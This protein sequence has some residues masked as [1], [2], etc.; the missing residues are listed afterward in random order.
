M[1]RLDIHGDDRE[2]DEDDGIRERARDGDGA[3]AEDR[4]RV[5]PG[6]VALRA[7]MTAFAR[8]S[9][10]A[11][12]CRCDAR[13]PAALIERAVAACRCEGHEIGAELVR[14]PSLSDVVA[15]A[16]RAAGL[17]E[18][19]VPGWRRRSRFSALVPRI[20]ARAGNS[21]SWRDISDPTISHALSLGGSLAW[22]LD[23]LIY[24]PNEPRFALYELTRRRERRRIAH[25]AGRAYVAW[26]E[27]VA[28][29]ASA[30]EDDA[31]GQLA[32]MQATADLDAL[33]DGWFSYTAKPARSP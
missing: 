26:L 4:M 16:Q 28:I 9:R 20:T 25:L 21:E 14:A 22:R 31:A 3:D 8:W 2:R 17:S 10:K 19:P 18:S 24:D 23:R 12:T 7:S 33:T 29:A 11:G 15:A 1:A 30:G 6:T 27:A 13:E 5:A 32:L